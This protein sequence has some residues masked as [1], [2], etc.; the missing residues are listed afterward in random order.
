M[1]TLTNVILHTPLQSFPVIF[2]FQYMQV[3]EN[4]VCLVH[5]VNCRSCHDGSWFIS[6][7]NAYYMA[8]VK[9]GGNVTFSLHLSKRSKGIFVV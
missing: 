5:G 4:L 9:A 2:F 1:W 6:D 7:N 8:A 3:S